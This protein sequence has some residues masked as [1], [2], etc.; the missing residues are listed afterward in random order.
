MTTR[1]QVVQEARA[2]LHT[3]YQ[4]QQRTRG[5][6][7]DCIGLVIGVARS[8]GLVPVDFDVNG[9]SRQP[10]P[11]MLLG[12]CDEHMVRIQP[13]AI[14][15]GDVI[16]TRFEED[17]THFGIVADYYHG[18]ALSMIHALRTRDGGGRV[19]EQRLDSSGLKR[20]VRAYSLPGVA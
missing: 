18:G 2:W 4:H 11:R 3:P 15:P 17:P 10:D 19:I 14:Q 1:A 12:K 5:V 20:I 8:L 16:V 6:A 7:V 13:E 9:Y